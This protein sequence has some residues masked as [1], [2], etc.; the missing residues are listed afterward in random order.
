MD[1]ERLLSE[2]ERKLY[3]EQIY[4]VMRALIYMNQR[5]KVHLTCLCLQTG[6]QSG[7]DR[8]VR[9]PCRRGGEE[10]ERRSFAT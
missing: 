10:K 8:R 4:D 6:Q 3:S 2:L 1:K 9:R 5:S 7:F